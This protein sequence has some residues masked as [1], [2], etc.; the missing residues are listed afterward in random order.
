M[1]RKYSYYANLGR[2]KPFNFFGNKGDIKL[3][4]KKGKENKYTNIQPKETPHI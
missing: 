2:T 4:K 1:P 3:H